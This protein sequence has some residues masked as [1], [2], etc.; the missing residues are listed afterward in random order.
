MGNCDSRLGF[1]GGYMFIKT[2][3]DYYY[4]G[5]QVNGRVYIRVEQGAELAGR[6]L[7][8]RVKGYEKSKYSKFHTEGGGEGE[9]PSHRVEERFKAHR[10]IFDFKENLF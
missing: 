1:N 4:P 8:L 10:I 6:D 9:E 7:L 3:R 2:D 5:N